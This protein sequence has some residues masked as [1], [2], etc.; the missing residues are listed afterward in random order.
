MTGIMCAAAGAAMFNP[1]TLQDAAS[2][3]YGASSQTAGFELR[4]DRTAYSTSTQNGDTLLY[5]WLDAS[6]APADYEGR[7]NGGAWTSLA[8]TQSWSVTDAAPDGEPV[9]SEVTIEVRKA[10]TIPTLGSCTI[11]LTAERS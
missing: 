10:S 7:A 3:S 11:T 4:S 1:V 2:F 9:E 8:T 5:N 6:A